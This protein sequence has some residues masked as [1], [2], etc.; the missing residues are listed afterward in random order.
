[1]PPSR[2]LTIAARPESLGAVTAFVRE[3]AREASLSE[4]RIGETDLLI[5]ELMMNVCAHGYPDDIPGNVT[6]TYS[7]PA[8][9]QLS[10]EVAD[11]GVEFNP[12]N[13]EAPDVTLN[14]D[15]RPIGGL[16]IYLVKTFAASLTYR[17][18]QGWN[19]LTFGIS[20]GT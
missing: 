20:A 8:P 13:A 2:S 16:G 5:E 9:G 18:D 19:R 10:V 6:I 1:V 12:L 11:Q 15:A 7:V 14:L 17:R 3:G 4:A